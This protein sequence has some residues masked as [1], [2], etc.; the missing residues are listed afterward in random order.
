MA[1]A[2]EWLL[3]GQHG[4]RTDRTHNWSCDPKTTKN[5]Y[6]PGLY[7]CVKIICTIYIYICTKVN[8][9]FLFVSWDV[10]LMYL[11][12]S[13]LVSFPLCFF[14]L[15]FG[16]IEWFSIACVLLNASE[17]NVFFVFYKP[18]RKWEKKKS[19]VQVCIINVTRCFGSCTKVIF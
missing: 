5:N 4:S 18:E 13:S 3:R 15:A 7:Y 19:R 14:F 9:K 17:N 16:Y 2:R 8:L 6:I 1:A 12:V 11:S 10:T